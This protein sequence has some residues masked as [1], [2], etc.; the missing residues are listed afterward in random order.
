MILGFGQVGERA[1]LQ[2][3][4]TKCTLRCTEFF[5]RYILKIFVTGQ[6]NKKSNSEPWEVFWYIEMYSL[7]PG[8]TEKFLLH[9][10][11]MFEKNARKIVPRNTELGT[12][13]GSERRLN[14]PS[15]TRYIDFFKKTRHGAM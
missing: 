6:C 3:E 11:V 7:H 14:V 4:K 15:R 2:A 9:C 13:R 1:H 12:L 8:C 5:F 10:A